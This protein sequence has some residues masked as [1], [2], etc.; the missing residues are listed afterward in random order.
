MHASIESV[1]AA[2]AHGTHV[3]AYPTPN[4][5]DHYVQGGGYAL[6]KACLSGRARATTS[7]RR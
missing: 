2:V 1:M 4:D 5:F 3:T 6:L 7:S